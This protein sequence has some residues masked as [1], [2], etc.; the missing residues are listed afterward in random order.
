MLGQEKNIK[1]IGSEADGRDY[2]ALYYE[3]LDQLQQT[4]EELED[5]Q[6]AREKRYDVEDELRQR[7]WDRAISVKGPKHL[8]NLVSTLVLNE[9]SVLVEADSVQTSKPNENDV[10]FTVK[11][12]HKDFEDLVFIVTEK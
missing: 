5:L 6:S 10:W 9:Y 4:T 12:I 2:E 8:N 1:T 11:F 7:I 3:T